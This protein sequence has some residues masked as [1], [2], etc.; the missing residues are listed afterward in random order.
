MFMCVVNRQDFIGKCDQYYNNRSIERCTSIGNSVRSVF[1]KISL[2]I[3][4]SITG[5]FI[6]Y[7]IGI[8]SVGHL[9]LSGCH[10]L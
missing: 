3:I 9:F 10:N 7:M 1:D 6:L 2:R 4:S 8:G 5:I